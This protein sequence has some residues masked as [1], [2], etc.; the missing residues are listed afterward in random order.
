MI[1]EVVVTFIILFVQVYNV[2]IIARVL[3]SWVVPDPQ[4]NVFTKIVFDLTEPVLAP[5]RAILPKS[6][7]IDLAPLVSFFLL[8]GLLYLAPRLLLGLG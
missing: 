2:L 3:S 8:Q 1:N 6:Q 7:F 4:S 5:I